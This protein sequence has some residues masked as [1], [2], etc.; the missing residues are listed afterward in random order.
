MAKGKASTPLQKEKNRFCDALTLEMKKLVDLIMPDLPLD[1]EENGCEWKHAR[2]YGKGRIF[3]NIGRIYK[4]C[5]NDSHIHRY[6]A[7][8]V[9]SALPQASLNQFIQL[10]AVFELAGQK[11]SDQ[12]NVH[13]TADEKMAVMGWL[14]EK[15]QGSVAGE[16][17]NHPNNRE[18]LSTPRAR[19]PSKNFTFS[20]PP[21]L[22]T[23]TT[24]ARLA[25]FNSTPQAGPSKGSRTPNSSPLY[26]SPCPP[27]ALKRKAIGDA[28]PSYPKKHKT[29]E[30]SGET[31]RTPNRKGKER[32]V[33]L[34]VI[35]ISDSEDMNANEGGYDLPTIWLSDSDD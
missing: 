15:A 22:A 11:Y 6:K 26:S 4:R 7:V 3:Y 27:P 33:F 35:E 9:S 19:L 8:Y 24:D 31:V 23:P 17:A 30:V 1:Y 18:I 25:V 14:L 13:S 20:S 21:Q 5:M 32:S 12:P 16:I 29:A 2:N 28:M 10:R 34:G